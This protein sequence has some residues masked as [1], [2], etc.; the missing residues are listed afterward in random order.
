MKTAKISNAD[1][2][3]LQLT[4]LPKYLV[5]VFG[6]DIDGVTTFVRT[7]SCWYFT[8]GEHNEIS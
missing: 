5:E 6:F 4:D 1:A 7:N 8:Q 3:A 2:E